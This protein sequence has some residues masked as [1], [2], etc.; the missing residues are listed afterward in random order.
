[1]ITPYICECGFNIMDP[2]EAKHHARMSGCKVP[3]LDEIRQL[4]A[5]I[6]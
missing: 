2:E 1:M 3:L 4:K 6:A 5:E